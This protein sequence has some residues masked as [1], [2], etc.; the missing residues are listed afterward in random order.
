[1]CKKTD[2][3]WSYVM[4][5]CDTFAM[6]DIKHL[7]MQWPFENDRSI[8]YSDMFPMS[9]NLKEIFNHYPDDVLVCLLGL[10]ID[11]IDQNGLYLVT[12]LNISLGK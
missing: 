11:G 6:E 9:Q 3:S 8:M 5:F 1:M 10:A 12:Q 7:V 2:I 4:Y